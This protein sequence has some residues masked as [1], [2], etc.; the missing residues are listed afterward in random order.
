MRFLIRDKKLDIADKIQLIISYFLQLVLLVSMFFSLL[1]KN[2]MI[3]FLTL[4]IFFLTFLPAIIRRTYRVYLP[5]EFDLVTIVFI[6]TSLFLGEIH[7]YYIRF[8]WW[9]VVLHTSSGF[10][11]GIAAFTLVYIL[12]RERKI[13]IRM[14]PGFVALF[15]FCFALAVG[16]V[17]EIFE[18]S[19]DSFF[20][21]NMQKSGL[22]DTMWDLIV[23]TLGAGIVSVLGY[24]Y[25]RGGSKSLLFRRLVNRF[26]KRNPQLFRRR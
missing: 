11:L 23:D 24:F 8:W 7:A 10:L 17:W 1:Q 19:M 2:W 3:L 15:S 25:I 6:F 9:D 18:F 14:K 12:N 16:T 5:V 22:V 13:N 21:L 4:G 26:V 20:S